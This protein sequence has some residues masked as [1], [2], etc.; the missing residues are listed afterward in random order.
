RHRAPR[1]TGVGRPGQPAIRGEEDRVYTCPNGH[2]HSVRDGDGRRI[3]AFGATG[4]PPSANSA[5][6]CGRQ[7]DTT[8]VDLHR[9]RRERWTCADWN[10]GSDWSRGRKAKCG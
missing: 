10:P 3:E 2:V 6:R 1:G 9:Q 5:E 4:D 8:D 7:E